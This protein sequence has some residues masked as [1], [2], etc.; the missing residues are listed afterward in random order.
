MSGRAPNPNDPIKDSPLHVIPFA[1]WILADQ[2]GFK[3]G[4][5]LTAAAVSM[6]E[7]TG[8]AHAIHINDNGSADYGCW[9]IN[10]EAHRSL[11]DQYDWTSAIDNATMAHIV[12][13]QAG[14]SWSP[15]NTYPNASNLQVNTVIAGIKQ[16]GV[17]DPYNGTVP[18]TLPKDVADIFNA[19]TSS[20]ESVVPG[21]GAL[22]TVSDF[23]KK[24]TDIHSW[25]SIGLILLGVIIL[26][27][28]AV[29][30]LGQDAVKGAK[31]VLNSPVGNVAKAV[32][33]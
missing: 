29:K 1:L 33:K 17:D 21:V 31:Q 12:W 26:I 22:Q 16:Y 30:I 23:L 25:V 15:W 18:P 11:F 3:G 4:D 9:Q 6:A 20:A 8:N 28:V 19:F 10:D 24:L 32:I 13:Q 2:A 7:S 5:R 14:G 27:V